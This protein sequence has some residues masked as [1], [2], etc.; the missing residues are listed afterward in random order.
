LR[1]GAASIGAA[2]FF[3][4][5]PQRIFSSAGLGGLRHRSGILAAY[6]FIKITPR[7]SGAA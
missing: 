6:D 1:E 4:D 3:F 7:G 5:R 2:L